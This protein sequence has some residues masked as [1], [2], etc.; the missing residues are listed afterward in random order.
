MALAGACCSCSA[1]SFSTGRPVGC[2]STPGTTTAPRPHF[3]S[4]CND[5]AGTGK[6]WAESG[7]GPVH[8][9]C[10]GSS[11]RYPQTTA[12]P[13]CLRRCSGPAPQAQA[14]H[15][16]LRARGDSGPVSVAAKAS[17][18]VACN[19]SSFATRGVVWHLAQRRLPVPRFMALWSN[20]VK[21]AAA[22]SSRK[23]AGFR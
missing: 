12:A 22:I 13:I 16:R 9:G 7:P 20:N 2:P 21:K 1:W 4:L 19:G 15:Q 23:P 8:W 17:M 6:G 10:D 18:K 11:H 3:C 5:P 14:M